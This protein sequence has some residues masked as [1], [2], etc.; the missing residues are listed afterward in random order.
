MAFFVKKKSQTKVHGHNNRSLQDKT[1]NSPNNSIIKPRKQRTIFLP[2]L[3]QLYR[4][5][6]QAH[7]PSNPSFLYNLTQTGNFI[8]TLKLTSRNSIPWIIGS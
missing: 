3:K 5:I 4:F 1:K 2:K 6:N 8:T 7:F